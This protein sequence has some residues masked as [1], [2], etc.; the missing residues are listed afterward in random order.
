MVTT[1]RRL[2]I[3]IVVVPV[4]GRGTASCLG[5]GTVRNAWDILRTSR[6][7]IRALVVVATASDKSRGGDGTTV[8]G[9]ARK[10]TALSRECSAGWLNWKLNPFKRSSPLGKR[11]DSRSPLGKRRTIPPMSINSTRIFNRCRI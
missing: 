3:S 11:K 8:A 4:E 1:G 6:T 7:V 5:H 2:V 10:H 9:E